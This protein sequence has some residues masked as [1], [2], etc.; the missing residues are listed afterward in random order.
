MSTNHAQNGHQTMGIIRRASNCVKF[1]SS[2][3]SSTQPLSLQTSHT[4]SASGTPP[5]TAHSAHSEMQS[6]AH[7]NY[8]SAVSSPK[9]RNSTLRSR[10]RGTLPIQQLDQLTAS[11]PPLPTQTS[12]RNTINGHAHNMVEVE[13][14]LPPMLLEMPEDS[15]WERHCQQVVAYSIRGRFDGEEP[16]NYEILWED[17]KTYRVPWDWVTKGCPRKISAINVF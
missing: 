12:Q 1:L 5:T 3:S 10:S 15:A 11:H 13:K 17:G 16:L 8:Q 9:S 14:G 2:S 4:N 6:S 7:D